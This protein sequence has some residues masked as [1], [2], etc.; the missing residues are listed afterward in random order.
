MALKIDDAEYV[1]DDRT[2][3][4]TI[5]RKIF[6]SEIRCQRNGN[7]VY[8]AAQNTFIDCVERPCAPM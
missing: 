5:T 4:Y 6:E 2:L 7:G 1:V 3:C 8:Q